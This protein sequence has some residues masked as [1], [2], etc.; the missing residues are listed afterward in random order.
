MALKLS[1][2]QL[3]A[4]ESESALQWD[5]EAASIIKELYPDYIASLHVDPC[6]VQKFC[7]TVRDH[8]LAYQI[9]G[10]REVLKFIII[11]ISQG[12]YFIHD[13]RFQGTITEILSQSDLPQSRR[14]AMLADYSSFWLSSTWDGSGIG[15]RGLRLVEII[16]NEH[17]AEISTTSLTLTLDGLV[18]QNPSIATPEVRQAFIDGCVSQAD[19]YGL[20]TTQQRL[21][22]VGGALLHGAYWF[23]DPLL[24]NLRQ[25]LESS[26]NSAE[27]CK[28]MTTFYE[29][30]L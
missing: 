15:T 14:I 17:R 29:G 7:R 25:A 4:F 22:Y 24:I 3:L 28:R 9:T 18:L 16:A 10:K 6:Q 23:D 11:A 20:R 26:T 21:A 1:S 8:A 5:A 12:A 13:P 19:G 27:L 2:D 30:F